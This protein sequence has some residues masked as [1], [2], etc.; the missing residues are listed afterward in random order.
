MGNI[1]EFHFSK[2]QVMTGMVSCKCPKLTLPIYVRFF[3][4]FRY[5]LAC[6]PRCDAAFETLDHDPSTTGAYG[7]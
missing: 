4:S 6:H 3:L 1:C 2:A 5:S 7:R